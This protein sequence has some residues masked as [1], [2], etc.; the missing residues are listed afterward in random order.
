MEGLQRS[1][2]INLISSGKETDAA[3]RGDNVFFAT[4]VSLLPQDL[5]SL[6]IYDARVD[7]GFSESGSEPCQGEA[8]LPPLTPPSAL[9]TPASVAYNGPGNVKPI[10]P[11]KCP[12]G[13]RR[14]KRKGKV[15]CVKKKK[16]KSGKGK[17][18]KAAKGRAGR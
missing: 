6:D 5:G 17:Y 15:R 11:K 16:G 4:P 12:K 2:C 10:K 3:E 14:V 7:G 8:C 13:K 1:G 9:P 18:R